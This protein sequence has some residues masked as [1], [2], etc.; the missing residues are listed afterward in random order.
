[1][2]ALKKKLLGRRDGDR[3]KDEKIVPMKGNY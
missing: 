1:M 3:A 2:S